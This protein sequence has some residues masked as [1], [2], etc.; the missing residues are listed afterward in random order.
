MCVHAYVYARVQ[1]CVF[2]CMQM[3]M[4][5]FM[6]LALQIAS[7]HELPKTKI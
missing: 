2:S 3:Y 6:F 1:V 5:K 4:Q 7:V